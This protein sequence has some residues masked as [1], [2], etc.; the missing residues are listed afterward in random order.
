MASY[1]QK[2]SFRKCGETCIRHHCQT[3]CIVDGRVNGLGIERRQERR[4]FFGILEHSRGRDIAHVHRVNEFTVGRSNGSR[5]GR[6]DGRDGE[7]M[8][9]VTQFLH[10]GI[11]RRNRLHR[12]QRR[13]RKRRQNEG[14]VDS[15][16]TELFQERQKCLPARFIRMLGMLKIPN[17]LLDILPYG[18]ERVCVGLR[19]RDETGVVIRSIRGKTPGVHQGFDSEPAHPGGDAADDR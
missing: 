3:C 8:D 12:F 2:I 16:H 1:R 4:N 14:D 17:S 19:P 7:C 9:A 13:G 18:I 10:I 15:A 11:P 5:V 6:I